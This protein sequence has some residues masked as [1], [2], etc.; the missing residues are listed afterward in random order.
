MFLEIDAAEAGDELRVLGRE[1][2]GALESGDGVVEMFLRDLN[3]GAEA[4]RVGARSFVFVGAVEFGERLIV[5]LLRDEVVDNASAGGLVVGLEREIFSVGVGGFG[6]PFRVER[7]REAERGDG[8]IW[9][10]VEQAAEFGFGFGG[11]LEFEVEAREVESGF[12]V[13]RVEIDGAFERGCG[14]GEMAG[15]LLLLHRGEF[16]DAIVTARDRRLFLAARR[17]RRERDR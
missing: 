1:R 6:L 9:I 11:A 7:L 5:I 3:V 17:R 8:G 10:G 14:I 4:E 2:D 12:G 13:A 16:V 15:A